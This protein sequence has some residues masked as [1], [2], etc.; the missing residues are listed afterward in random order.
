M[1]KKVFKTGDILSP[2]FLNAIQNPS[3]ENDENSVGHLP[4]PPDYEEGIQWKTFA[5]SGAS[6]TFALGEWKG[7]SVIKSLPQPASSGTTYP[8]S[9]AVN[10]DAISGISIVLP[11]LYNESCLV[12]Y[13]VGSGTLASASIHKGEIAVL[14]SYG[15][16]G[17][18]GPVASIIVIPSKL[19]G[20]FE[21][22]NV[23]GN[24]AVEGTFAVSGRSSFEDAAIEG[25]LDIAE[26]VSIGGNLDVDG[27]SS[28]ESFE[29]GTLQETGCTKVAASSDDASI[30]IRGPGTYN[31][32]SF[33]YNAKTGLLEIGHSYESSEE[34]FSIKKALL[35]IRTLI[36]GA[37]AGTVKTKFLVN[38]TVNNDL[39]IVEK[40]GTMCLFYSDSGSA[41]GGDIIEKIEVSALGIDFYTYSVEN[42]IWEAGT[43]LIKG[44]VLLNS[45]PILPYT[46]VSSGTGY[47]TADALFPSAVIGGRQTILNKSVSSLSVNFIDCNGTSRS[48]SIAS[49][50][51]I[52]LICVAAGK[53]AAVCGS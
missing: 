42:S 26:N 47:A 32:E 25:C 5:A 11:I 53:F 22:L 27:T 4:L 51:A 21:A 8:S 10:Q 23:S 44:R 7:N 18:P 41:T 48:V 12:S 43:A 28:A 30:L 50:N 40:K 1:D 45:A 2:E 13:K 6:Q 49:G 17:A 19:L 3:F 46:E 20:N 24:A 33:S 14:S 35:Q 52:D 16:Y 15:A 37:Q 39:E 34:V 9:I 29:T 38:Q 36:Y 31:A